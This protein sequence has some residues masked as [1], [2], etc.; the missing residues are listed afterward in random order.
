MN[1]VFFTQQG[2]DK[3][4]KEHEEL[5]AKRKEAV[6]TLKRAREMGDLSENGL[7]KAAK[8]ELGDIDRTLRRLTHFINKGTIAVKPDGKIGIGSKVKVIENGITKDFAIVGDFEA[9]P[10]EN[11]ISAKSPLGKA[12][13]NMKEAERFEIETPGGRKSYRIL[14]IS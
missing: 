11:K 3:I 6:V 5:T 9:N 12:L 10:T 1:N 7:Y 8:F 2:F 13:M 4:K 14:K